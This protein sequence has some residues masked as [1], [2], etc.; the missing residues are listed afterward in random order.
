MSEENNQMLDDDV[1]V[2]LELDDGVQMDCEIITIFEMNGQD[3]IILEPQ[4]TAN[5]PDCEE[6]ELFVY[7]YFEDEEGNCS[8]ENIQS[9]EEYEMVHDRVDE[10]LDEAYFNEM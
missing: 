2:T 5:D 10:L 6:A 9:D 8:L 1:M 3:Y 4:E 7:R